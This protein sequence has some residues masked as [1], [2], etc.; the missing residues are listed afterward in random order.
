MA[1]SKTVKRYQ[2]L[3]GQLRVAVL[4][5]IRPGRIL[6]MGSCWPDESGGEWVSPSFSDNVVVRVWR[7]E[8]GPLLAELARPYLYAHLTNTAFP[9]VL[10]GCEKTIVNVD[11]LCDP[12]LYMLVLMSTGKPAEM[13]LDK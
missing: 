1:K 2:E 13:N 5:D 7:N 12:S 10:T 3:D 4:E 11:R 8:G 9:G 6:R